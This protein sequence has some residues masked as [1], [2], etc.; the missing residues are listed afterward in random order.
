M[1]MHTIK[2]IMLVFGTRP[3]AIKMAPVVKALSEAKQ[4]DVKG[5]Y[6]KARAGQ[7]AEFTGISSPYETPENPEL[8]TNTGG[9]ALDECVSQVV[10]EMVQRGTVLQ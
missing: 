7:I 5:M 1:T 10:G 9:A 8:V 2:K 3:E 4:R 6:K